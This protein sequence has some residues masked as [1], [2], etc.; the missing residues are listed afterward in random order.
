MSDTFRYV[1]FVVLMLVILLL[2]PFYLKWLGYE[3]DPLQVR[4]AQSET[5]V[6]PLIEKA[7]EIKDKS[8]ELSWLFKSTDYACSP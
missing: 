3:S 7:Q 5:D 4:E 1:V 8:H 2:Q 6:S